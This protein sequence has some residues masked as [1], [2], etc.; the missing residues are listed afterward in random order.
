[1]VTH[2]NRVSPPR[3]LAQL[4]CLGLLCV[5]GGGKNANANFCSFFT[6]RFPIFTFFAFSTFFVSIRLFLFCVPFD[7]HLYLF[8]RPHTVPSALLS[9]RR[10][11]RCRCRLRSW[12]S[13]ARA[14]RSARHI[15]QTPLFQF[16]AFTL[17]QVF[18]LGLTA[19]RTRL[20]F[21]VGA[22]PRTPLGLARGRRC[23]IFYFF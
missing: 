2:I 21:K 7:A 9:P 5:Q 4:N 10:V 14:S 20:F 13:S 17:S 23:H 6:V 1:M 19:P 3:N 16:R 12:R 8:D 15:S 18:F 11:R 22:S